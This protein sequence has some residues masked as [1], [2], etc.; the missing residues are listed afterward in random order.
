MT[1]D[2]LMTKYSLL[3]DQQKEDLQSSWYYSL[4]TGKH[5][6]KI[7]SCSLAM[8]NAEPGLYAPFWRVKQQK[9]RDRKGAKKQWFFYTLMNRDKE[10]DELEYRGIRFWF[11]VNVKYLKNKDGSIADLEEVK[12]A[13]SKA[14]YEKK[15]K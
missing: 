2:E 11:L 7:A 15:K 3:T 10:T 13:W 6:W 5:Y 8:W 1:R 4:T 14:K 9:K 12:Q